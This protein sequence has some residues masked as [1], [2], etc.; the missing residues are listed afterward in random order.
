MKKFLF[1]LVLLSSTSVFAATEQVYAK[2]TDQIARLLNATC[3]S[4]YGIGQV[5]LAIY[6]KKAKSITIS[7]HNVVSERLCGVNSS[8]R[9]SKLIDMSIG[10]I[11]GGDS[12]N[13]YQVHINTFGIVTDIQEVNAD[14]GALKRIYNKF[15]LLD[16][17]YY[18]QI[19]LRYIDLDLVFTDKSTIERIPELIEMSKLD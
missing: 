7:E 4:R 6:D 11:F 1:A 8:T 18:E 12:V 9:P 13:L 5:Q 10:S 2:P 14:K 15:N 17:S 16:L 3:N 19:E